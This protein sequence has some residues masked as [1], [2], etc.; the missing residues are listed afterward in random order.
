MNRILVL[1]C[2]I[3][4]SIGLAHANTAIVLTSDFSSGGLSSL[5]LA[6]H[7]A[8][9]D[10][11]SIH[12]DARVRVRD[13]QVYVIN[14]LGQDNIIVLEASDLAT[15]LLQFSTGNGTNPYDIAF[16]SDTK[17]YVSRYASTHLLIV[18]PTSGDSL[19]TVDLSAFADTDGLPEASELA[20]YDNHLFIA[21]QRIDRDNGFAPTD[22][23][24]IAVVDTD[25][26]TLIDTQGIVMAG[27]NPFG[28]EQRGDKWILSNVNTFGDL[29][30]G[31]I[32]VIDL[33]NRE[34][35]G[36]LLDESAIGGNL[37]TLAMV[38]DSEG[39]LIVTDASFSNSVV[40]FD[41][42]TKTVSA[43]LGDHSGGFT[44]GLAVLG[45]R[46]Y[47]LDQGSFTDPAS[48][49]IKVY[50]TQA[51]TL[52]AGPIT[53]GL[54]PN[55]IA[56]IEEGTGSPFDFS[57]FDAVVA[58]SDFSSGGL[59]SLD[60]A[61]HTATNDVLSIHA[62]ARVRVRDDQVYVINRLGQDNII[63]LEA[64][65]L[66][67]PLLQFSTGNG[68]NP[69]DIAFASDTKAYVSRYASTHLLIVDPTSGDSLGTVD[70]SAF[71]DTDGLPEA[72]ELALYDNHLFIAC[73]RID[74]DNGFAPTDASIIA[75]VDTDTD[76]LI[77]TQGIVM[78]GKNPFG[79]EQRG[80][81]W[82]LSNVNTF[83]DLADGGIEVIDLAN[84]ETEGILLDESAIGGNLGTL[85]MVS[86]SEGYL[87][88]T[89]ASFSN[90]VVRFDL[91]TKTVSASLGDHSG[92]FTPGL[93]VLG[94]RLYVLDQGSFTDP[95][96]GGIKVYD[97]QANTLV[98]GPITAGLPPNSI[99]F[100]GGSTGASLASDFDGSG[101]VGFTDFLM[102]AEAFGS[103]NS[104]FDL[105][106]GG[107][108]NFEDFLIFASEFGRSV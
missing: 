86:D 82:I 87:I 25:T 32:E 48:G 52:V 45:D 69:Y 30:D 33:A 20:L 95:A 38:S 29:A 77:D 13:D 81:K 85:A 21:C 83:G 72:S 89:D 76:T 15:P 27:K 43:S 98:A 49:G 50:D 92:G 46:L 36:I 22:A 65:D 16:A 24:I 6:T 88:V 99:A 73:Q 1:V 101:A 14:R 34:T 97:T 31:G 37:G 55:S 108:V 35:E 105:D 39:Y 26:D 90:S 106:N 94:D 62:D 44:P 41:L 17:A 61:T 74:R 84:R 23:S 8:T 63:V 3:L 19:G 91:I 56:F 96:S 102:F 68:T 2:V 5:D 9:N 57:V 7:T 58:T 103:S 10:V 80:D 53:A 64:S 70:L 107:T 11:L 54:P 42:I 67:T 51:N 40:R 28:A 47:V 78:A 93:A 59:S 18:D 79:A 66:A 4:N 12:A 60:L 75:V 71:A 100:I 104:R